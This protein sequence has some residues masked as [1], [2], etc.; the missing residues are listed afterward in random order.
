MLFETIHPENALYWNLTSFP[1]V[2]QR[3]YLYNQDFPLPPFSAA[4]SENLHQ[5][6]RTDK[7]ID[8]FQMFWT[9][10]SICPTNLVNGND[11]LN[12]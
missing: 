8:I 2:A 3:S 5:S 11:V 7:Q 6:Y 10:I 9:L 4:T 1:P 12:I